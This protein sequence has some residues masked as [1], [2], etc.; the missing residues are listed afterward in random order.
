MNQGR[1]DDDLADEIQLHLEMRARKL[2]DAGLPA[3][4]AARAARRRCDRA[5]SRILSSEGNA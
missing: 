3:D 4:E 1:F 2:R 5:E